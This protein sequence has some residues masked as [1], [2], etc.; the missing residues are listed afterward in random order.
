MLPVWEILYVLLIAVF[1]HELTHF[2]FSLWTGD[3]LAIDFNEFSPTVHFDD[4]MTYDNQ[5]L[6]YGLAILAG[7][8]TLLPF[9]VRSKHGLMHLITLVIYLFGCQYD[10]HQI[11]R[12]IH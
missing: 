4:R 12:I 5:L 9:I 1:V 8:V 7:T 10:I 6:M 2:L 3:F 11:I